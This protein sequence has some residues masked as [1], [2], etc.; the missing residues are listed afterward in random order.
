VAVGAL[1]I[2]Q[3]GLVVAAWERRPED[4]GLALVRKDVTLTKKVMDVL[5]DLEAQHGCGAALLPEF[6]PGKMKPEEQEWWKSN[7]YPYDDERYK[8]LLSRGP[9]RSRYISNVP[10]ER[11]DLES[12]E[13]KEK[14]PVTI[15]KSAPEYF[16]VP[17]KPPILRHMVP[18]LFLYF[19]HIRIDRWICHRHVKVPAQESKQQRGFNLSFLRL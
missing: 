8:K 4:R 15:E 6:F 13:I 14:E 19:L 1:E 3:N 12:P 11:T 16:P 9:P 2:F 17:P 7:H 5:M 10:R 18:I